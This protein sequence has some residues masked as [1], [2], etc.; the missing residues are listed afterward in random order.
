MKSIGSKLITK[1]DQLM[2]MFWICVTICPDVVIIVII[3]IFMYNYEIV[4]SNTFSIN[5]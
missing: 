5:Y 3:S 4:E 2:L 1:I